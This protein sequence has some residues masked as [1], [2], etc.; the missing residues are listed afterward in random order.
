MPVLALRVLHRYKHPHAE[1]LYVY[2]IQKSKAQQ[3]Q[4][5]ANDSMVYEPND[6]AITALS[7]TLLKD[8]MFIQQ[9][10]LRGIESVGMLLGKSNAIEGTDLSAQYEVPTPKEPTFIKWMSIELLHNIYKQQQTQQK[11]H[12]QY[13]TW[14]QKNYRAKIKLD[15]TNAGIQILPD[16]QV[17]AQSRNRI[18]S[19]DDDNSAFAAW[20]EDKKEF[21]STLANPKQPIVVFGEWCGKNIQKGTAIS[22]LSKCI[23][24]VFAVQ[25]GNQYDLDSTVEIEPA[26]IE[27]IIPKHSDIHILPWY[28]HEIFINYGDREQLEKTTK[29]IN[30]MVQDIS[31]TDPWVKDV[32]GVEG[33]GEGL[34]LYP[35]YDPTQPIPR[36][37]LSKFIFKA[38]AESHRVAKHKNAVQLAPET[39]KNVD[40]FITMFVTEQRLKQGLQEACGGLASMKELGRFLKWMGNDIQKES[41]DELEV[42]GLKWKDVSRRI[43]MKSKKWFCEQ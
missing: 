13:F 23:F 26:R 43:T 7:N 41:K 42:N 12:R 3:I 1:S 24:A 35:Q 39:L 11:L 19:I 38:K 36:R 2:Q 18:L 22:V 33:R 10:L 30:Q 37:Q 14:P 9:T 16:G 6:I 40:A 8:G 25:Y 28:K 4:I 20:L 27:K 34:V 32:F 5:I 15:G 31:T 29:I 17:I 21:F